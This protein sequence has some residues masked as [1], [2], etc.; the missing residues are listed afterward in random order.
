MNLSFI[1]KAVFKYLKIKI[2]KKNYNYDV[3]LIVY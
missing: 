2:I 3:D 1:P